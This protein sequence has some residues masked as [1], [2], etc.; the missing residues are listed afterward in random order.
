VSLSDDSDYDSR[1]FRLLVDPITAIA[2]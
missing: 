1:A 2:S